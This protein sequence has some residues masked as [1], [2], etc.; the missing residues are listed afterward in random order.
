MIADLK[1][2]VKT[3][4][5]PEKKSRGESETTEASKKPE[6]TKP[7]NDEVAALKAE[8]QQRTAELKEASERLVALEREHAAMEQISRANTPSLPSVDSPKIKEDGVQW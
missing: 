5:E 2:R 6:P 3:A 1:E 7:G 4:E 8:L